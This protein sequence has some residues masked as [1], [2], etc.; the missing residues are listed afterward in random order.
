MIL[1]YIISQYTVQYVRFFTLV[2]SAF[3]LN[4]STMSTVQYSTI[5]SCV[6]ISTRTDLLL[7]FLHLLDRASSLWT[8]IMTITQQAGAY[9]IG[10]ANVLLFL[11][12]CLLQLALSTETLSMVHV[13]RLHHLWEYNVK[14]QSISTAPCL[15]L[16][17]FLKRNGTLRRNTNTKKP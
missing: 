10:L 1:S 3:F 12:L 8:F 17:V 15:K 13:V 4:V 9:V 16:A 2:A 5:S 14:L 6:G 11:F 7:H